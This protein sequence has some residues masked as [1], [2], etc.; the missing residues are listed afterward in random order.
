MSYF[1]KILTPEIMERLNSSSQLTLFL[2]TNDA[3]DQLDPVERLYLESEFATDDL[4]RILDMHA[5]GKDGVV[6]SDS[7][8][9][10]LSCKASLNQTKIST[11]LHS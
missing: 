11:N 5:V 7:F 8:D 1:G 10:G 6:W 2:P 4:H 3:W 9:G